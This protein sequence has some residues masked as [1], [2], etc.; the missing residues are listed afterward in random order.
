MGNISVKF[1]DLADDLKHSWYF[2]F[3]A[4]FWVVCALVGFSAMILYG[5]RSSEDEA[6]KGWRMWV[7]EENSIALPQFE[8]KTEQDETGNVIQTAS[9]AWKDAMLIP[10]GPCNDTTSIQQ[11]VKFDPTGV[12][13][14]KDDNFL[15]CV[16]NMTAATGADTLLAFRI[17]PGSD[18]GHHLWAHL[19][20]SNRAYIDLRLSRVK[21]N[22]KGYHDFWSTQVDY[23]T[24]TAT[25][26]VYVAILR[27]ESFLVFNY[28]KTDWY[29]GWMAAA[30]I[31]GFAFFL[32]ILHF[33]VMTFLNIFM[34]N[35]SKFLGAGGAPRAQYNT[36]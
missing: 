3:W 5:A 22:S 35:N 10:S 9:C 29:T 8:F 31:G 30:D 25:K 4:L 18:M 26:Y 33:I 1:A 21:W 7:K 13:L 14:Q 16:V 23:R 36:L 6:E 11:C 27:I 12:K 34:E 20:P 2:R 32:V 15:N 19:Q 28:E 24:S 17:S